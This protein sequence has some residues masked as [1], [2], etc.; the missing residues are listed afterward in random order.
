MKERMLLE[1]C[2]VDRA[3][4]VLGQDL[5]AEEADARHEARVRRIEVQT[6]GR[7]VDDDQAWRRVDLAVAEVLVALD[8]GGWSGRRGGACV[9]GRLE[10]EVDVFCRQ[11][12]AV[13]PLQAF[14][15]IEGDR[16]AIGAGF[17]ALGQAR[18]E[19]PVVGDCQ[20]LVQEQE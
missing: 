7:V 3:E 15:E 14:A 13:A 2:R 18:L 6:E 20:Q 17:P 10:R 4:D 1:L 8:D 12:R 16:L 5:E 11:R 19:G 9:H